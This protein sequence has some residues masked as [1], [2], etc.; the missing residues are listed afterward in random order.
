M[1][2]VYQ[3][4]ARFRVTPVGGIS[5]L[6][7]VRCIYI[8]KETNH[9]LFTEIGFREKAYGRLAANYLHNLGQLIKYATFFRE[10]IRVCVGGEKK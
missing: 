8:S 9:F 5:V 4:C 10:G 6:P 3:Q 1:R 7:R 2:A